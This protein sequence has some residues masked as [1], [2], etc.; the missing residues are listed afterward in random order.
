MKEP[1]GGKFPYNDSLAAVNDFYRFYLVEGAGH[2]SPGECNTSFPQTN[3]PVMIDWVK[4]GIDPVTLN[5][6]GPS[7]CATNYLA[8]DQ[9]CSWLLRPVYENNGTK[10]VCEFPSEAAFNTWIYGLNAFPIYVY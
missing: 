7:S 6:T 4:N 1:V 10:K 8:N 3:F 9:L 2:C 5:A